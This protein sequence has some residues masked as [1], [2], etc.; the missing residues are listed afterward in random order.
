LNGEGSRQLLGGEEVP[1]AYAFGDSAVPVVLVV[2][3]PVEGRNRE[4]IGRG[5]KPPLENG[6]QPLRDEIRSGTDQEAFPDDQLLDSVGPFEVELSG[7][8]MLS[9]PEKN[10]ICGGRRETPF[11]REVGRKREMERR[12]VTSN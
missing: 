3:L 8:G 1:F 4:E 9:G 2:P 5:E 12:D 6:V 7:E 10:R 11:R